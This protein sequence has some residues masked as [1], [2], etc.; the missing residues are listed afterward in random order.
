MKV[1]CSLSTT[2]CLRIKIPVLSTFDM[3]ELRLATSVEQVS[4]PSCCLTYEV[5]S[6]DVAQLNLSIITKQGKW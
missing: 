3:D 2:N 5:G 1:W 6:L 4:L